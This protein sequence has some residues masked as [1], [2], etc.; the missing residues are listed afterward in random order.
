VPLPRPTHLSG[1][2]AHALL[3]LAFALLAT[4]FVAFR[5]VSDAP[6]SIYD[7]WQ[8]A[9]RVHAVSQGHLFMRD[10]EDVTRWGEVARA[11]RGVER[12][13]PPTDCRPTREHPEDPTPNYAASD[14]PPYFLLT[15]LGTATLLWTGAVDS[16]VLAGRLVGIVWAA[17]SMWSLWLL[18]RAFGATRAA[19]AVAASTVVL[20]PAF[21]QQYSKITPHA[22]DIPVGALTALAVLRYLQGRWPVWVLPLAALGIV[23]VKGSNVV[24]AVAVGI[25]VAAVALWPGTFERSERLRALVAGGVL[26]VSTLASFAGFQAFLSA[27]RIADYD[28][29]GNYV[30]PQLDWQAVA[31]D[32]VKFITPWGEGPLVTANVWLVM[33]MTGTALA[34]WAGLADGLPAYVRQFAP[35]YL[36]GAAVGA[37]VLDLMV[38][39]TSGQYF[40]VLLRYGL[41][42]VPLGLAMAALLLRS[43]TA[44]VLAVGLLVTYSALSFLLPFDSVAV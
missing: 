38:F 36:L 7:E 6:L 18:A 42:L 3:L 43:R 16:P 34:I 25:A 15:G 14:P 23:G 26:L 20:V 44:L 2:R 37:V 29:P 24:V 17:L 30:V 5:A 10:G 11:C 1:W 21:L 4:P 27:T 35:G 41:A 40:S 19:S 31:V 9:D 32:S 22:L 8:Y 33:A 28:P 13:M 12:V 39:T